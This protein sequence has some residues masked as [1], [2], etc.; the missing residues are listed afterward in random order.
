[1]LSTITSNVNK[2]TKN[3]L[4]TDKEIHTVTSKSIFSEDKWCPLYDQGAVRAGKTGQSG[5]TGKSRKGTGKVFFFGKKID[6]F[7]LS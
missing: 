4:N 5:E 7:F 2:L 1:M 6:L 3:P